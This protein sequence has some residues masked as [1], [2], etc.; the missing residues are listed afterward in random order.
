[1]KRKTIKQQKIFNNTT[2]LSCVGLQ[3]K[4][5]AKDYQVCLNTA[6]VYVAAQ[7]SDGGAAY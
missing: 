6:F 5:S 7:L 4:Y 3:H 1:M 2:I